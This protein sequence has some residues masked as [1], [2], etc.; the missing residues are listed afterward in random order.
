MS[1]L[2]HC[3]RTS[4]RGAIGDYRCISGAYND[5]ELVGLKP[6]NL[7]HLEAASLTLVAARFGKRLSSASC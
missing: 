1:S 4:Y 3:R 2:P 6:R 5:A 7:T